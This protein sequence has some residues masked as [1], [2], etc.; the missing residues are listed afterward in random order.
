MTLFA[1]IFDHGYEGE[2]FMGVFSS[3][4]EALKAGAKLNAEGHSAD[5]IIVR[6]TKVGEPMLSW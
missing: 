1:L 5:D 4:E 6:E 2:S 3:Y